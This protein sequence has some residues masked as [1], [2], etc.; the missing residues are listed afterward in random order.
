MNANL[1]SPA[2]IK[3]VALPGPERALPPMYATNNL[4]VFP[5]LCAAFT[6]ALNFNSHPARAFAGNL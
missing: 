6:F 2:N 4:F 1:Y 3:T 5:F